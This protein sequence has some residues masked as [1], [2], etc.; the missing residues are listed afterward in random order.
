MVRGIFGVEWKIMI[1]LHCSSHSLHQVGLS[2]VV[3]IDFTLLYEEYI[4]YLYGTKSSCN[5]F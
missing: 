3:R 5:C 4:I 2:H 1:D